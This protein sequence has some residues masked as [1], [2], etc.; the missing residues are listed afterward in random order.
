M[1]E[2]ADIVLPWINGGLALIGGILPLW[3]ARHSPKRKSINALYWIGIAGVLVGIGLLTTVAIP[4]SPEYL[5]LRSA[6]LRPLF[7][8]LYIGPA[9]FLLRAEKERLEALQVIEAM[10]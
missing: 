6:I 9:I 2:V 7:W 4:L 8:P 1:L 10:K 5:Q 3:I